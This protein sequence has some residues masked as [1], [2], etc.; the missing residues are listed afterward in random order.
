MA[1]IR[2]AENAYLNGKMNFDTWKKK[3][4]ADWYQPLALAQIAMAWRKLPPEG[5]QMMDRGAAEMLEQMFGGN[6]ASKI[7]A[8]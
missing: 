4:E 5:R 3:F 6:D 8:G 7:Q 1:N 2:D